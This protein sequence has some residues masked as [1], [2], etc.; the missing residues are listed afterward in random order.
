M[1]HTEGEEADFVVTKTKAYFTLTFKKGR[2]IITD[3]QMENKN[4]HTDCE[5]FKADYFEAIQKYEYDVIK[6]TDSLRSKYEWLPEEDAR[7]REKDR[8]A[9][10]AAHPME[11]LGF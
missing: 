11:A 3:V 4:T 2:W 6:A 7:Q 10:N 9:Y 5:A 1:I 8:L